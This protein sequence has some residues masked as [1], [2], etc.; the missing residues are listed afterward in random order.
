[1]EEYGF[2]LDEQQVTQEA[3]F[4]ITYINT[5]EASDYLLG[6]RYILKTIQGV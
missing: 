1:M 6:N 2:W 4:F 5:N 3:I